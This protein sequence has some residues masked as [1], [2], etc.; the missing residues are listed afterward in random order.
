MDDGWSVYFSGNFWRHPKGERPGTEIPI[1]RDF[2]W[3]NHNWKLLSAYTCGKGL[4]LDICKMI[5]PEEIKRFMERWTESGA[6]NE[7]ASSELLER[8]EEENPTDDS[9]RTEVVLN[10][11]LLQG[12]SGCGTG[13]NPLTEAGAAI[14]VDREAESCMEHYGLDREKGWM[15]HRKSFF[16]ATVRKPKIRS[17]QVILKAEYQKVQGPHLLGLTEGQEIPFVNP[18]TGTEHIL[19]VLDIR[20]ETVQQD[21][22]PNCRFELPTCF[23]QMTYRITPE[24]PDGMFFLWDCKQSDQ[25]RR[26]A[27]DHAGP[28]KAAVSVIGGASGPTAVFFAGKGDRGNQKQIACSSLHFQPVEDVEWRMV[29]MKQGR[30]DIR[31]ELEMRDGADIVGN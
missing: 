29:F 19:T 26:K 1:N 30:E 23:M 15:F 16:W 25:P 18:V 10:G 28:G 14:A 5:E 27:A 13:W 20:P 8:L 31:L 7:N 17:L 11:K 21:H 3:G 4:I 12:S 24:I 22:F 2:V 9:F 6:E